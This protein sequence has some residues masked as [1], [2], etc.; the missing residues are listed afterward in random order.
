MVWG[1]KVEPKTG[2]GGKSAV[3]V[4][5][6]APFAMT[7]CLLDSCVGPYGVNKFVQISYTI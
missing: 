2:C 5:G 6:G 7:V 1:A 4:S 3:S